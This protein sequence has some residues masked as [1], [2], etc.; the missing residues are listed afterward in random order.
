MGWNKWVEH[1][2]STGVREVSESDPN[3]EC[4]GKFPC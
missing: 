3:N 2:F 4:E 1:G